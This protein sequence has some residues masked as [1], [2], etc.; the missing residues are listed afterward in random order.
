MHDFLQITR[1]I[2]GYLAGIVLACLQACVVHEP[3]IAGDPRYSPVDLPSRTAPPATRGSL[4]HEGFQMQLFNDQLAHQVGDV[5]TVVLQESTVSKKSSK[6]S[7]KKESSNDM[8]APTLF[9]DSLELMGKELSAS[10]DQK[11]DFD[12]EAKADQS[13]SLSGNITVTVADVLP[14]GNLLV[15]GEKWMELNN[16][17]EFIRI[18]GLVRPQDIEPDNTVISTRLANAR[19][20]YSGKGQFADANHMGWFSR[21]FNSQYWPF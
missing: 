3:P 14:N 13:N 1:R 6:S 20:T 12:G 8:P 4:Y 2:S 16:G 11:R 10:I 17:D 15:R 19:I 7:I 5:I 18:S 9:G 21:F